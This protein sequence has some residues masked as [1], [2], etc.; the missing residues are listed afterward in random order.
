MAYNNFD[1]LSDIMNRLN[2]IED[3]LKGMRDNVSRGSQKLINETISRIFPVRDELWRVDK[4][5]EEGG[6]I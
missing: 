3:D 1:K 2:G 4:S 6:G 5:L